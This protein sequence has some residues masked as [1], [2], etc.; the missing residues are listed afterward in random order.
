MNNGMK[1]KIIAFR[2]LDD[3]D[4]EFEDGTIV[5]NK[6]ISN[7]RYGRIALPSW[8]NTVGEKNTM[9]NGMTASVI[10]DRG[11][12][13]IDIRFE[14]G[15]IVTTTR[16]RFRSGRT[17]YPRKS[18]VGTINTMNCGLKAKVISD[19]GANDLDVEFEDGTV[20]KHRAKK[21]FLNGHIAHPKYFL[22]NEQFVGQK[23]R[24][25]NGMYATVIAYRDFKDIDIQFDDGTIVEHTRRDL[26]NDGYIKNPN[27]PTPKQELAKQK[28]L[29][30]TKRMHNGM[31]ATVIAYRNSKD[32]DVKFEDGTIVE[33]T[34][35][36]M[37]SSACIANPNLIISGQE[38][39]VGMM[40]QLRNG[41]NVTIVEYR[42]FTDIDVRFDDG[43][44]VQTS[45]SSFNLGYIKKPSPT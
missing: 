16:H 40:K 13:D 3:L 44:I 39:Y 32:I 30:K 43:T 41:L 34:V 38:K 10:E 37:F 20:I 6:H 29:G 27:I 4:I 35:A 23:K 21:E 18:M 11:A 2:S 28:Y 31:N 9:N 25:H 45:M 26:F 17:Q 24:M 14:D 7:F 1:A 15:T 12:N 22:V 33:H 5:Y 19:R 36:S 8:H 42:K